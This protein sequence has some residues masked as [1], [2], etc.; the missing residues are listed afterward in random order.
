MSSGER[1]LS[2][3]PF[4]LKRPTLRVSRSTVRSSDSYDSHVAHI[5]RLVWIAMPILYFTNFWNARSFD[6]PLAAHLYNSTFGVRPSPFVLIRV[7]TA[8]DTAIRRARDP[9]SPAH[10]QRNS[11]RRSPTDHPDALLCTLLRSELRG[12]D[13]CDL[14]CDSLALGRYKVGVWREGGRSGYSRRE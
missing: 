10:P 14:D 3:L 1:E 4:S 5:A 13:E 8:F 12:S 9:H 11:I 2:T 7:L 6:S